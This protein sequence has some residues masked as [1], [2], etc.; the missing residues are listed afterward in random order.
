LAQS[1]ID[2]SAGS[3]LIGGEPQWTETR[4]TTSAVTAAAPSNTTTTASRQLMLQAG[5]FNTKDSAE[6]LANA[7]RQT[8]GLPVAVN[9]GLNHLSQRLYRVQVG[10]IDGSDH[11]ALAEAEQKVT[12]I[13]AQKPLVVDI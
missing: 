8:I 11:V 9:E 10:P 4:T 7:L 6:K 2:V 1:A 13:T 5:A 3:A 12:A